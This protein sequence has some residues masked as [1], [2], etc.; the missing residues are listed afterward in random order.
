M[1]NV[2]EVITHSATVDISFT[3]DE[4]RA[5]LGALAALKSRDEKTF[6]A[7]SRRVVNIVYADDFIKY[8]SA[9]PGDTSPFVL[10]NRYLDHG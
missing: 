7:A 1:L 3:I 5:V 6:G 8:G 10:A 4:F 2:K 9:T